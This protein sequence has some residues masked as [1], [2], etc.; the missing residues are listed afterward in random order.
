MRHQA[1]VALRFCL[2]YVSE[3]PAIHVGISPVATCQQSNSYPDLAGR[4]MPHAQQFSH[5]HQSVDQC[6]WQLLMAPTLLVALFFTFLNSRLYSTFLNTAWL[7]KLPSAS[8]PG[9]QMFGVAKLVDMPRAKAL[10]CLVDGSA[11]YNLLF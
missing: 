4:P 6:Q 5:S 2:S 3:Q 1:V 8:H 11:F 7:I 10:Q 9:P